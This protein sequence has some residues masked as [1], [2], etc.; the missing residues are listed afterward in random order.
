MWLCATELTWANQIVG[1]LWK[2]QVFLKLHLYVSWL[3]YMKLRFLAFCIH[4]GL[5]SIRFYPLSFV[6]SS[7]NFVKDYRQSG[8][9]K[10]WTTSLLW[11]PHNPHFLS[12]IL[13]P[14]FFFFFLNSNLFVPLLVLWAVRCICLSAV[15]H[16]SGVGFIQSHFTCCGWQEGC[17]HLPSPRLSLPLHFM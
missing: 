1:I 11:I 5:K 15:T 16:P 9:L 14:S 7:F 12:N 17:P 6:L 10:I 2:L 8:S 3:S 13:S 4:W